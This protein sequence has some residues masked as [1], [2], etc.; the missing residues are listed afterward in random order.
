MCFVDL[1]TLVGNP[2][3]ARSS[4]VAGIVAPTVAAPFSE[5]NAEFC[6]TSKEKSSGKVSSPCSVISLMICW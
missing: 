6:S 5:K 3:L 4:P 1:A 2:S